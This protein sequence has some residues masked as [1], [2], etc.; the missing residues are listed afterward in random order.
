ME[1]CSP[2]IQLHIISFVTLGRTSERLTDIVGVYVATPFDACS[3]FAGRIRFAG[4]LKSLL[5]WLHTK[6]FLLNLIVFHNC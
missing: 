2:D 6:F 4:V 1:N 5:R 3:N